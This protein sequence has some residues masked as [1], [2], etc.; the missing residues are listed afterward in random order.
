MREAMLAFGVDIPGIKQVFYGICLLLVV[1]FL[2]DGVWPPLARGWG[3]ACAAG[4]QARRRRGSPMTALLEVDRISKSFSGLKAMQDVSF[5]VPEGAIVGLIGPNGAGKTTCFNVIAGVYRA[6]A[7]EVRFAGKRI[8]GW[9]PDQICRA[10]V[11]RTFQLV[12]PFAGLTVMER[13]GRGA[14][15]LRRSARG[16]ERA[17]AS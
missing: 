17:A 3:S 14:Q 1:M 4:R 11:G 13:G 16:K 9:R 2:P 15:R 7:G 6:D 8:D 5:V 12:K 10:G